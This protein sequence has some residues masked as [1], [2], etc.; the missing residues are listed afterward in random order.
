MRRQD[1]MHFGEKSW[2]YVTIRT[3]AENRPL[4][5]ANSAAFESPRSGSSCLQLTAIALLSLIPQT[6]SPEFI[7]VYY[8]LLNRVDPRYRSLLRRARRQHPDSMLK[9]KRVFSQVP[10]HSREN[11]KIGSI[12]KYQQDATGASLKNPDKFL[13]P[14]WR[15][16]DLGP[17]M[18]KGLRLEAAVCRMVCR[19]DLLNRLSVACLRSPPRRTACATSRPSSSKA[20]RATPW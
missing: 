16:T 15:G 4:G 8:L 5:A 11:A 3:T 2:A 7:H 6:P 12:K 17:Q 9:E 13:G 18:E 1:Y 20:S 14:R 10:L 19:R